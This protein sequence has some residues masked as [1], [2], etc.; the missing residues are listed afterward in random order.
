MAH[1][2]I[3][4]SRRLEFTHRHGAAQDSPPSIVIVSYR[5]TS[6]TADR[7]GAWHIIDFAEALRDL[8]AP[9]RR[10]GTRIEAHRTDAGHLSGL[11]ATWEVEERSGVR[12]DHDDVVVDGGAGAAV[13]DPEQVPGAGGDEGGRRVE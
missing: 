4:R 1:V 10:A 6:E 13:G 7:M 8:G 5:V 2:Q 3:V 9:D 11:V 12:A